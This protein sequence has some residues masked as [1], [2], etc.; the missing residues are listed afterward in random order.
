MPP[1]K[2]LKLTR[3]K[4]E[5]FLVKK[6][7]ENLS[8]YKLPT[9]IE[10][11]QYFLYL[12]DLNPKVK[13][14]VLIRCHFE[15]NSFELRCPPQTDCCVMSKLVRPWNLAG[16]PIITLENIRKKI[17]KM[18][19]NYYKLKKNSKR[20]SLTDT[21][22]N[23]EF[24]EE[25]LKCFWISKKKELIEDIMKD[26]RRTSKAKNEDI[27]FIFDQLGNRMGRIGTNDERF[28]YTIKRS[29]KKLC[30]MLNMESK[31]NNGNNLYSLDNSSSSDNNSDCEYVA[32]IKKEQ[33]TSV[34]LLPKNI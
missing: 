22:R 16:F 13:K 29:H 6:V 33:S 23:E 10:V 1:K 15:I 18:V 30:S 27:A 24:F 14:T 31:L 19:N 11:L 9:G 12:R 3:N 32:D 34:V 26:R 8:C 5:V 17:D 20:N 21:K 28:T 4:T 25:I 2:K 7:I